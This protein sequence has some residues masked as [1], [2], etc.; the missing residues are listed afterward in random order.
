MFKAIV[1]Y[2]DGR[3]HQTERFHYEE[4]LNYMLAERFKTLATLD[5][6]EQ[7]AV[8]GVAKRKPAVLRE[9][10]RSIREKK[11]AKRPDIN[12]LYAIDWAERGVI[13][14]EDSLSAPLADRK[15]IRDYAAIQL[16]TARRHDRLSANAV[17]YRY[18]RK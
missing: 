10:M 13:L 2:K 1:Y 6:V 12:A 15:R 4:T 11:K 9:V 17:H 8:M 18:K 3:I 16:R 14:V 7:I 5:Q